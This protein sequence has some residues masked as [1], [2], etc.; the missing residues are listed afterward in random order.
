ML[1]ESPDIAQWPED[2]FPL[3]L[4]VKRVGH[5]VSEAELWGLSLTRDEP[6]LWRNTT[7]AALWGDLA[8]AETRLATWLGWFPLPRW[9]TVRVP[10]NCDV[11]LCRPH[12]GEP[13]GHVRGVGKK[14]ERKLATA[15]LTWTPDKAGASV[16]TVQVTMPDGGGL[17]SLD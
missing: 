9:V 2:R 11:Y 14:V 17:G 15:D 10:V 1:V 5:A 16:A 13:Y 8:G 7:R 6:V 3:G 12:R 4:Y